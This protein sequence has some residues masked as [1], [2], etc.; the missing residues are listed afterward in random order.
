MKVSFIGIGSMGAAMVPNLVRAGHS[1]SVWNRNRAAAQAI[2]GVTVLESPADAFQADAVM[3]MLS[4]DD[5]VRSV[6]LDS[7]ALAGSNKNCVHIMMATISLALVDELAARHREAGI[8]YVSAPVFGVPAAAAAAQLNVLAAGDPQAIARVQ[9]LLDAV[10]RKTWLLGEDPKRA[11][12]VKISGNMMIAQAFTAMGEAAYLSESY[13]VPAADLLDVLTN[14][15][16]AAP[17][18]QRYGGFIATNTFEPGFKLPLGLKDVNLALSAAEAKGALL[19]VAEQ[20]R[21]NM[22]DAM[23]QGLQDRDWSVAATIRRKR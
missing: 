1:V 5:A 13:G 21:E 12:V 3:T 9:P 16:F 6:I 14:T 20:V 22:Q 11:N 10:G 15:L 4:N 7:G 8:A 19:P 23:A 18:Y 17:S 2:D